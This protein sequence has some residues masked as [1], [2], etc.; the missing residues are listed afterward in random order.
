MERADGE[1]GDYRAGEY[2][3]YGAQ[4]GGWDGGDVMDDLV[5]RDVYG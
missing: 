1:K 2:P 5:T 4:V 3:V